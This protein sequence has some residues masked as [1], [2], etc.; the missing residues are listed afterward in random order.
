MIVFWEKIKLTL[1]KIRELIQGLDSEREGMSPHVFW[2]FLKFKV[3]EFSVE[4]SHRQCGQ[5][6]KEEENLEKRLKMLRDGLDHGE[7]VAEEID[8]V[9]RDL[10]FIS[11]KKA[12]AAIL[13]ARSAVLN[14]LLQFP[15]VGHYQTII[16]P[17][18]QP[19]IP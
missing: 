19:N 14:L 10:K 18:P 2:D 6:R 9:C 7:D 15:H 11:D 5:M 3:K 1:V 16:S 4:Y 8:S 17:L 13:R 12:Q